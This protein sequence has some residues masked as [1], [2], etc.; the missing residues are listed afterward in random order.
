MNSKSKAEKPGAVVLLSGGMDSCVC[1]ALVVR[2][3]QASALHV[4]YGQRTEQ[5]ERQAFEEV[6]D[7]LGIERRLVVR[8]EA[9]AAIGG[10]A[11]TD[12]K[13]EVP[14]AEEFGAIDVEFRDAGQQL[15]TEIRQAGLAGRKKRGT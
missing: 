1:A 12:P 2:D 4:M 7:H 10:S 8:N 3:Y 13:L 9:L 15:A 14:E 6:C 5:R 11:L